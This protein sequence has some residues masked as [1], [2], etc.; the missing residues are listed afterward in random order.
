VATDTRTIDRLWQQAHL[1]ALITIGYNLAEGAISVWFGMADETL[2]LFGFGV[3]SFVEVTSGIAVWH[4]IRRLRTEGMEGRDGF[5]R[6]AL[7]ITG[8]SFYILAGSLIVTAVLNLYHGHHPETTRWGIAV[9]L[10][11][12]LGMWLL[13]RHK[14]RVGTALASPA[15]LADAACSRTCLNLSLV[16]LVASG[17]YELTGV[18]GF[19]AI[20]AILIAW[21]AWREGKEAFGK[22]KGL[23]CRCSCNCSAGDG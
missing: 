15:I 7:K 6:N 4:M 11:S 13:I 22:S 8:V 18:S 19:D 16:L 2:A 14:V 12:L 23:V 9:S 1:L 17:G 21:L 10:V 3:D 5:E 20:G